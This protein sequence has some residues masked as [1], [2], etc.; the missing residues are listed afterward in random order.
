M[1]RT[2]AILGAGFVVLVCGNGIAGNDKHPN[3]THATDALN[4]ASDA[5]TAA[6]NAND[7]DMAGHAAAAKSDIA[8]ALKQVALARQTLGE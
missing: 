6:Q 7:F 4:H 1:K 3:L 8:D 2:L 5:L